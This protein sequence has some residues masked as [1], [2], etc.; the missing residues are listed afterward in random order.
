[1]AADRP[2]GYG[3]SGVGGLRASVPAVGEVM[4]RFDQFEEALERLCVEHDVSLC[5]DVYESL[6]VKPL[7]AGEAPLDY[8]VMENS[9]DQPPV[10]VVRLL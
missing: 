7:P 2:R 10:L 6:V 9:I 1:V 8:L 3:K 4:S 5:V